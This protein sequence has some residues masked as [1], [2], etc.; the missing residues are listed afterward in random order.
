MLSD[1]DLESLG[2]A[3]VG[4]QAVQYHVSAILGARRATDAAQL[5]LVRNRRFVAMKRLAEEGYFSLSSMRERAPDV[6]E[7]IVGRV[8]G[9]AARRGDPASEMPLTDMLFARLDAAPDVPLAAGEVPRVA[10]GNGAPAGPVGGTTAPDADMDGT[11]DSAGHA[12]PDATAVEAAAAT[13]ADAANALETARRA[14][15]AAEGAYS[16]P[17]TAG[18]AGAGAA[19]G[20]HRAAAD[21]AEL[22]ALHEEFAA[23]M[24]VRFL[25]GGDAASFD[26]AV[27]DTDG[28]LDVSP[29]AIADAEEAWFDAM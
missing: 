15:A 25:E 21:D 22:A 27:V 4:S 28:T 3:F 18:G 7:S 23:A 12:P 8:A 2:R 11:R 24:R 14:Q 29:E 6:Y 13:V 19:A 26:Y 10:N 16:G 9:E 1:E 17:G 20:A 5:L